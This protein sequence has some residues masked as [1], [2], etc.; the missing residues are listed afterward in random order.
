MPLQDR[1]RFNIELSRRRVAVEHTLG[2]LKNRFM[3]LRGLRYLI[4]DR[5]NFAQTLYHIRACVIIHNMT[6]GMPSD[7]FWEGTDMVNQRREWES[8]TEAVR[9]ARGGGAGDEAEE[10]RRDA[11]MR[12]SLRLHLQA[13]D[14]RRPYTGD[15]MDF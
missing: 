13:T 7:T 1:Q 2:M 12:E 9:H 3:S 14:H 6:L 4:K 5:R 15:G 10:N 8:E 11:D